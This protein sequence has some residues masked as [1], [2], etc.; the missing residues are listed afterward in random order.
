MTAFASDLTPL[1]EVGGR[2]LTKMRSDSPNSWEL[3]CF[4]SH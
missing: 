2:A 1:G 4:S 3:R